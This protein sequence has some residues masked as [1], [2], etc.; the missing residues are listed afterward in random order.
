MGVVLCVFPGNPLFKILCTGLNNCCVESCLLC[1]HV[2]SD[3]WICK[4]CSDCPTKDPT[5]SFLGINKTLYWLMMVL[6]V[7][8]EVSRWISHLQLHWSPTIPTLLLPFSKQLLFLNLPRISFS[9][10]KEFCFPLEF[11][12]KI[13]LCSTTTA[14]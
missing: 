14:T 10:S 11:L 5:F 1:C 13:Q 4:I 12:K 6:K 3:C 8:A 2:L 9:Y 7:G